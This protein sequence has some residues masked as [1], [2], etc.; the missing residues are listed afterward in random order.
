[1]TRDGIK[2][3]R[4]LIEQLPDFYHNSPEVVDL[5]NA[6]TKQINSAWMQREEFLNQLNV[7]TATWSLPIWEYLYGIEADTTRSLEFRRACILS[8]LRGYG[9]ATLEMMKNVAKSF[10]NSDVEIIEYNDE[11]RFEIKF[12][13]T[14]SAIE[15]KDGFLKA[16][17]ELKPA[18]LQETLIEMT[19]LPS[20]LYVGT[21]IGSYKQEVICN[22]NI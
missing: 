3:I 10:C 9:T 17:R 20:T 18:H 8:K 21:A 5:Q 16:I 2:A 22:V 1:M 11:F 19:S 13:G 15:N 7:Q 12:D 14:A 4:P 6:F